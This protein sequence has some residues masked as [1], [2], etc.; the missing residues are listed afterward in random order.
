MKKMPCITLTNGRKYYD[1]HRVA[2]R[3]RRDRDGKLTK[4][5]KRLLDNI[6]EMRLQMDALPWVYA[7]CYNHVAVWYPGFLDD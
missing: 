6:R 1:I 2:D 7:S 5:E 3:I 4:R